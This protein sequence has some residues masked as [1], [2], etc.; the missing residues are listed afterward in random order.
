M[1][2]TK[3]V[4][5]VGIVLTLFGVVGFFANP[6]IGAIGILGFI[7]FVVARIMED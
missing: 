5:C 7:I 6:G 4:Q 2:A 1:K 3:K